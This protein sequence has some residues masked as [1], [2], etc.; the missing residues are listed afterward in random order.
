MTLSARQDNTM[1]LTVVPIY[2]NTD[3]AS[4]VTVHRQCIPSY[5]AQSF[6][7]S[8]SDPNGLPNA[9]SRQESTQCSEECHKRN[10]H[11]VSGCHDIKIIQ[12]CMTN[13]Q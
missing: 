1:T 2:N 13:M 7:Q 6:Q 3:N 5:S 10:V 4:L 12:D 11:P 8:A 9:V